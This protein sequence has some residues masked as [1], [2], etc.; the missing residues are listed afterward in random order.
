M[1]I[2]RGTIVA[3]LLAATTLTVAPTAASAALE[4]GD[5]CTGDESLSGW[6][7]IVSNNGELFPVFPSDIPPEGEKVIT[8][9]TVRVAPEMPTTTQKLVVVSY[10]SESEL[11]KVAESDPKTVSPGVN[12]FT[13]RL[14]VPEYARIGLHGPAGTLLCDEEEGRSVLLLSGDPPLGI[15]QPWEFQS[16]IGVPVTVTFESIPSLRSPSEPAEKCTPANGCPVVE[17]EVSGIAKRRA[18]LVSVEA[19]SRAPVEVAGTV[20]WRI[21]PRSPAAARGSA[22][23]PRNLHTVR[24]P[25]GRKQV[26]PGR[27]ARFRLPLPDAVLRRLATLSPKRS[28]RA[29]IAVT[30]TDRAD[31]ETTDKIVVEL[32]GRRQETHGHKP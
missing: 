6:T 14:H 20:G 10:A 2:W 12:T 17:L 11:R 27:V 18:I 31:V 15:A 23:P 8:S 25:G 24:L 5:R 13:T 26:D 28:L 4:A 21:R 29:Q 1:L 30:A 9:W 19:S 16:K 22:R 32:R 7:A 3:A